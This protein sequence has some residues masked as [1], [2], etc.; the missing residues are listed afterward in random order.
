MTLSTVRTLA[1]IPNDGPPTKLML[2]MQ[3]SN[4]EM[5]VKRAAKEERVKAEVDANPEAHRPKIMSKRYWRLREIKAPSANVDCEKLFFNPNQSVGDVDASKWL[6]NRDRIFKTNV[7]YLF[8]EY[9]EVAADA[10]LEKYEEKFGRLPKDI[11][12]FKGIPG[13]AFTLGPKSTAITPN[14]IAQ[15]QQR[16]AKMADGSTLT[17]TRMSEF[18]KKKIV[19]FWPGR[20]PAASM[21]TLA[22]EPDVGKSLVTLY[23]AACVT[24]GLPFHGTDEPTPMGE[25]L[26]L[27]AE[28]DPENTL[29]PRLEAAGADLDSVH[30]LKSVMVIDGKGATVREREAQLDIDITAI[31]AVLDK[32]PYIRLVIIDPISSF[33]GESASMNKEQEVRRVL[34]PLVK[35]AQMNNFVVLLVAH[36]NKNSETRSPIDKVGGAKALVSMGRSAWTCVREPK[37][38]E[39][40]PEGAID[41]GERYM[42]LKLKGN[43]AK[44]TIGGLVYTIRTRD[45]EVSDDGKLVNEAVPYVQFLEG[46]TSTAQDVVIDGKKNA[47]RPKKVLACEG[48][49]KQH[50]DSKGGFA[51]S[52]AILGYG[53]DAGYSDATIYRAKDA[54]QLKSWYEGRSMCWGFAL[55]KGLAEAPVETLEQRE[56]G[57]RRTGSGRKRR[58]TVDLDADTSA[59]K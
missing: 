32:N 58:N 52:G 1:D 45:V 5:R 43:L 38:D 46:T 51:R 29:A 13:P 55:P 20:I 27:S 16:L 21:S 31:S 22:G 28:D 53:N 50:L 8:A 48:W 30:L 14:T 11:L 7:G 25:V 17:V 10:M 37:S 3:R 26:I 2:E 6:L 34:G 54:L 4:E 49:L 57:G 24:R 33:L 15:E 9:L 47:G 40:L 35:K 41:Q 59:T 36:F 19:W 23:A 42:F 12:P 56:H 44:S 18:E 39:P